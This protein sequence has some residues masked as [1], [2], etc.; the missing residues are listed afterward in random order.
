[1][2]STVSLA[3]LPDTIQIFQ[4]NKAIGRR[5]VNEA[6]AYSVQ[7]GLCLTALLVAQPFQGFLDLRAFVLKNTNT[8]SIEKPPDR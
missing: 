6:S 1:L 4:N 7:V 3:S 8:L 5:I 2:V